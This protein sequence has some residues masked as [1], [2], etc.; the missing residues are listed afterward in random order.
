MTTAIQP[1][2]DERVLFD[3]NVD[4]LRSKLSVV[5]THAFITQQRLVLAGGQRQYERTDLVDATEE[6]HGLAKKIVFKTTGGDLVAMAAPDHRRLKA[7]ADVLMGRAS[8]DAMPKEP[9]L[10][11]VKSGTAWFAALMPL[12]G[13]L[14]VNVM[15]GLALWGDYENWQTRHVV[16][17][18]IMRL[19][20]DYAALLIDYL[21]LQRQGFN[22]RGLGVASPA[23][24]PG[25]LFSRA[26]VFGKGKGLAVTWV[27]LVLLDLAA[28]L[29]AL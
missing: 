22:V 17:A 3:G 5:V 28:A 16:I 18:L 24:M 13:G 15:I 14:V 9:A 26:R 25:Y 29:I 12:L 21:S 27:V 1:R 7:A 23:T 19:G 2:A 11:D 4:Y 6:K 8:L 20:L 10:K